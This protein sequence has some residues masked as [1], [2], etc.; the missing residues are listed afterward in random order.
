[1]S[2]LKM[3][4]FNEIYSEKKKIDIFLVFECRFEIN[5]WCILFI[6][7]LEECIEWEEDLY[8]LK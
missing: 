1:M 3:L 8:R 2:F 4:V 7:I 5:N 6:F